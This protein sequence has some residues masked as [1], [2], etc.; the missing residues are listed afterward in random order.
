MRGGLAQFMKW[1]D[2]HRRMETIMNTNTPK[3][4]REAPAH[5]ALGVG[6]TCTEPM[7]IV[8]AQLIAAVRR[9]IRDVMLNTPDLEALD[10][11][12]ALQDLTSLLLHD[13]VALL[14]WYWY[15]A[16]TCFWTR[17]VYHRYVVI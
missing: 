1:V 16:P 10:D 5:G 9:L 11:L 3:N 17:A 13:L 8:S 14:C 4:A 2:A 6:L 12:M 7:L 15:V